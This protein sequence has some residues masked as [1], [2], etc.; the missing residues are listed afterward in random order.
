MRSR[1]RTSAAVAILAETALGKGRAQRTRNSVCPSCLSI[2]ERD[3]HAGP[4]LKLGDA[5]QVRVS[6]LPDDTFA[7]GEARD[8]LLAVADVRRISQLLLLAPVRKQQRTP[9]PPARRLQVLGPGP[10]GHIG[11]HI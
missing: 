6:N 2:F 1:T 5:G 7:A 10:R 11:R 4:L 9:A 8:L 3:L